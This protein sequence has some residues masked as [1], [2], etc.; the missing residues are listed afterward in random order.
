MTADHGHVTVPRA[1]MVPVPEDLLRFL[2][3]AMIAIQPFT[4]KHLKFVMK[5]TMIAM[6]KLTRI[7]QILSMLM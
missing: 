5:L 3:I 1:N 7:Q 4:Q 2:V 6:L